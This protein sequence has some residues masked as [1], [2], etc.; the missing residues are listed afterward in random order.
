MKPE[1]I[2]KIQKKIG[3]EPDGFWGPKSIA[4]CQKYLKNPFV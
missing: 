2:K 1:E 4:A 3:T